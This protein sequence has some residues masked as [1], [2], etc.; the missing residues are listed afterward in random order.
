MAANPGHEDALHAG[1]LHFTAQPQCTLCSV[2]LSWHFIAQSHHT[3][4]SLC[5]KRSTFPHQNCSSD[6]VKTSFLHVNLEQYTSKWLKFPYTE[7]AVLNILQ[8]QHVANHIKRET[9]HVGV[10]IPFGQLFWFPRVSGKF[11][12]SPPVKQLNDGSSKQQLPFIGMELIKM[13]KQPKTCVYRKTTNKGLLLHYQSH[14]DARYKRSLLMTML[15]HAQ[16]LSS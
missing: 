2:Q 5:Q 9:F 8:V 13:G 7:D 1:W 16:C 6:A 11:K 4:E 14:V 15:N 3:H 10:S 12:R